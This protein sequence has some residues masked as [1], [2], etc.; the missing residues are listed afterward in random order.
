M[1]RKP[2]LDDP[3]NPLV[4]VFVYNYNGEYLRQ[5]FDKILNQDILSNIEVI[6]IDNASTDGYWDIA[7]EYARKYEGIITIKRDNRS[8]GKDNLRHCIRMSKGKYYV[9]LTGDDAF[10]PEYVKQCVIDM[11]HNPL[12]SFVMV[13][14]RVENTPSRPNIK[15][16]PLVSVLIHN[17]NYGRYLRQ[18]FDSVFSQTYDNVEVV[19]S[20]NASSDESWDIAAEYVRR[21][22]SRM[23]A[24]R[25]RKNFGP[26][27]NLENC[28]ASINGKYFCVLCSDDAFMPDFIQK[29]VHA[30]EANPEA[31][32]AMTHRAIIDEHGALAEEPPFYNQSCIIPGPEQAAVY[33]M[34]AVNPSI[35]QIMYI[36]TKIHGKL[37]V[38]NILS[39]WYAQRLLD[40]NLCCEH[41]MVYLNDPL[42]L[43]RVH[44]QSDSSQISG[45]LLEIF[46]QYILPHQFAEI[47]L[48]GGDM[49]KVRER[50]P[51][52][53][54]K[55]GRLCLRYCARALSSDD[56]TCA[57]RY[58][59]MAAAIMPE[60]A[61]DPT[62]KKIREYW[63][64]DDSEKPIIVASLQST[65]NLT[66]RTIS[67]DPP[68]G[69]VR[70]QWNS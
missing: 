29:C 37:P 59:H 27:P 5:C 32:F 38:E 49:T 64:A 31:G 15:D 1:L 7:L 23:I 10:S 65:D 68:P 20:D 53:L 60:I 42:L 11:E 43:H 25:N 55:V 8:G 67:Y 50:L 61:E 48:R 30:L 35:S 13:R 54:E 69:S 63:V 45:N 33:M 26:G 17:Y 39:R 9:M 62:F 52:A 34:A 14:R 16:K 4:S 36:Q 58:F 46:G 56:E 18:C 12:A 2:I 21:Y 22:P 24:I 41:P 44:S 28:Y 3:N 70:I 66:T 47:S 19:F 6:F 51:K 40:F 57:L